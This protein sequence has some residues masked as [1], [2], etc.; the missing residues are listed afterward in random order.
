[1]WVLDVKKVAYELSGPFAKVGAPQ[2]DN[3][4]SKPPEMFHKKVFLTKFFVEIYYTV[5]APYLF[6]FSYLYQ[7]TQDGKTYK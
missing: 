1:M 4:S 6:G 5:I 3:D 7:C 2:A